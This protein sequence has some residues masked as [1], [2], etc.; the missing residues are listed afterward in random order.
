[1]IEIYNNGLREAKTTKALNVEI[2]KE[3]MR[4]FTLDFDLFNTDDARKY[5]NNQSVLECGGQKF[6]ISDY[7]QNS[8]TGNLTSVSGQHISYRLNNYILPIGYQF[9]GTVAQIAQNIL[10]MA[11]NATSQKANTEFTI[12]TCHSVGS[13]LFS[14]ENEQEVTARFAIIAMQSIGVEVDYDNFVLNFPQRVGT[15]NPKVFKFGVDLVDFTRTWSK[16]NGTTYEVAIASLQRIEGHEGDTFS[17]G[18]HITIE[19][20]F[21]GDTVNRR[22]ISYIR[23]ES[24]PTQDRITLGVF[25]RDSASQAYNVQT[26]LDEK[27]IEGKEYNKCSITEREG[28]VAENSDGTLK[29]VQ[30]ATECFAIYEKLPDDTYKKIAGLAG[31]R[32]FVSQISNQEDVNHYA[33]VGD[34]GDTTGLQLFSPEYSGDFNYFKINR[35]PTQNFTFMSAHE[36]FTIASMDSSGNLYDAYIKLYD[37]GVDITGGKTRLEI[38]DDG[39]RVIKNGTTIWQV[40]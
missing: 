9:F 17:E 14:L 35:T 1:M 18:D 19:D 36:N 8:G 37:T 40:P 13:V 31:K 27:L 12:G 3:L 34:D 7:R 38:D 24:D 30:N 5:I 15:V 2:K 11:E 33:I 21:L 10:N 20:S 22:I 39:A 6:D 32:V 23:N 26:Q 16:G 29:A 4:E 25:I 28:F